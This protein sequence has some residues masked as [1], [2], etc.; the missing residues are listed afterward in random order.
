MHLTIRGSERVK[1]CIFMAAFSQDKIRRVVSDME[2][3]SWKRK[4][5]TGVPEEVIHRP[6]AGVEV[7]LLHFPLLEKTGIVKEGFTTRLGGVSE[8]IFSTMNLSFTR[9]DE[10]EAVRENYRRLASAL[11]V[12]YDKFVF[13]DQTHTT[14]VRKVTAEDAGNGLTRER[15]FHDTDGLITDV[16]GLVLS[17]FY[18]DCVPLYFVDPVHCAIG[19]SHSGWRGTVNRMG[20]TTIEAMRREYGSRPE[21]LRCAIGPSICQDCY[22]VSG[23]VAMEF[24][25]AFAGHEREILLAK[26]NGKYQLNLWKA[27]EIVLLDA[28]VLPE[29]IEITDICTCC[30]PDLLFSHRAS[31]GKR[32]NLGAFLCLK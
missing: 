23:D 9:G 27:N 18:A 22:E 12:D 26:E 31:H 17:T 13:T 4:N 7:P 6:G 32:G 5:N 19:L 10:E 2:H 11:G 3:K 24:E 15:E 25:Q 16:P 29:H 20:K 30:N 28:G 1:E 8:G 21:E 14:N